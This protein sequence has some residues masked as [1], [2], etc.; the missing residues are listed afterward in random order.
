M[1]IL[2][3]NAVSGI[4]STGRICNEIADYLNINGNEGYIAYSY[5]MTYKNGYKIGS[6]IEI[7]LHS[8]LS[9][10]F[11]LQAYFS[12]NGT[13][14]LI[15]KIESLKPD[16]IHLH[17]LHGNYI[18]LKILLKYIV[19]K[20]IPTVLTLHDCWFFTGKCCY[21]TVEDCYKWERECFQCP[22]IHKDNPSWFF[23][24]SR[25]MY[26]D[27][28]K[29]FGKIPFLAVVCVSNWLMNEAKESFLAPS[30]YIE[31]IYNWVDLEIFKPVLTD[32]LRNK[33]DLENKFII[34]G[35]A[36]KWGGG[37]VNTNNKGLRNF[38]EM[39]NLIPEDMRIILVGRI[40]V[41]NH[42]PTNIIH[43]DETHDIQ[44]LAEIYSMANVLI[45][46]SLEETFGMVT[47]EA[48][49]C[50]TPAIVIKSTASPELIGEGC[51]YIVNDNDIYNIIQ[52]ILLIQKQG[53]AIYTENCIK[54]AKKNFSRNERLKDY[55]SLYKKIKK[56]SR[57]S[58]NLS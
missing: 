18:N 35:V 51:G 6:S 26:R 1:K 22:R 10:F 4:R 3:I 20:K 30:T 58:D 50:G 19:K 53:K 45:N 11:G 33:L 47:A 16:V 29:W 57:I 39:A 25:R 7:K 54:F 23:D 12:I 40:N 34:L 9:R 21:Y 17:N 5:G 28:K 43:I 49:A 32:D 31:R 2:Q 38:I 8:F 14:K 55:V 27:K 13:R 44:E 48:L 56:N 41:N 24:N 42:L 15:N 36:S 37:K 46:F 52:K